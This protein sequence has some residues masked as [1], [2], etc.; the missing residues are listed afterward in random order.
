MAITAE[1]IKKTLTDAT[2][3]YA[4]VG[5]GDLAV[6]KL[7]TL[8]ERFAALDLP[9][10]PKVLRERVQATAK[11]VQE[12]ARDVQEKVQERFAGMDVRATAKTQA[13]KAK[14]VYEDLAARG[15]QI[16]ARKNENGAATNGSAPEGPRPKS[17]PRVATAKSKERA[18][19]AGASAA[20]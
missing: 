11:D 10:D 9:R 20:A 7:K 8:P 16:V 6:E 17:K 18:S 3:L 5:A 15:Q 12:K 4:V 1:E 19:R 14:V 13:D 2:P